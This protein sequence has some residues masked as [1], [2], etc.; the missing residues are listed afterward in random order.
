MSWLLLINNRLH[1][2]LMLW[3]DALGVVRRIW[4]YLTF[5]F[6]DSPNMKVSTFRL[7]AGIALFVLVVVLS[8]QLSVFLDRRIAKR[9]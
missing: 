8:G 3:Q 5:R 9:T 1:E 6:V 7:I 2:T 4:S